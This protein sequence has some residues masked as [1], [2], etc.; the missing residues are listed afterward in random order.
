MILL[1]YIVCSNYGCLVETHPCIGKQ[2]TGEILYQGTN[3]FDAIKICNRAL[4]YGIYTFDGERL[5]KVDVD[6]ELNVACY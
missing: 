1:L 4:G 6:K 2:F 5:Y 3:L